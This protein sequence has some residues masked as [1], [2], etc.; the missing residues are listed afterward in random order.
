MIIGN[1][2]ALKEYT[3]EFL[4]ISEHISASCLKNSFRKTEYA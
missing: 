1:K 4:Q 3:I 2:I